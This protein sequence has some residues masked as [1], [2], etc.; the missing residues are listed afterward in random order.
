MCRHQLF[1]AN[2]YGS[3]CAYYESRRENKEKQNVGKRLSREE[4]NQKTMQIE[5]YWP[6]YRRSSSPQEE[7][8]EQYAHS[9]Y[10]RQ[11]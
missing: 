11:Y 3:G 4:M 7:N 5:A 2:D 1:D 6:A 8:L 9:C 10:C